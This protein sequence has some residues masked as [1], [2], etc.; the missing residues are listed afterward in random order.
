MKI[1]FGFCNTTETSQYYQEKGSSQLAILDTNRLEISFI[2]LPREIKDRGIVGICRDD[3]SIYLV[4]QSIDMPFLVKLNVNSLEIEKYKRL[5]NVFDPHSI[6]ARNDR[7]LI[8]S[9]GTNSVESF[10]KNTFKHTDTFWQ[11]P[12]TGR[13]KDIVH[14]N[15]IFE[16]KGDIWVSCFGLKT[17]K[18]WSTAREGYLINTKNNHKKYKISHPHSATSFKGSVYYCESS[19]GLVYKN[20]VVMKKLENSYARALEVYKNGFVVGISSSRIRSKSTGRVNNPS[21]TGKFM[22][23]SGILVVSATLKKEEFY[24]LTNFEKE[25][26]DVLIIDDSVKPNNVNGTGVVTK[27]NI[28]TE[29]ILISNLIEKKELLENELKKLKSENKN[30]KMRVKETK[31]LQENLDQIVSSK[32]YKIYRISR[33]FLILFFRFWIALLYFIVISLFFFFSALYSLLL[34]VIGAKK[35][36]S[37]RPLELDGVSFIIPTWNK[38]DMVIKCVTELDKIIQKEKIKVKKEIIVVDNGSIDGTSEALKNIK[39]STHLKIISLENNLGFA[40]AINKATTESKY[41]YIY[42]LNNDMFPQKGFLIHI[43]DL[44]S[45]YIKSRVTFFGIASQ[46]VMADQTKRREESGKTYLKYS[47]GFLNIAHC[48]L[49]GNLKSPSVTA[50][51]GGGSSLINKRVFLALGGYDH[52]VFKPLYVEDVDICFNAWRTGHPSFFCPDSVTI[53][54]HRSSSKKLAKKPDY[55][56]YNNY[57]VFILKNLDDTYLILRHLLF[58]SLRILTKNGYSVFAL[59]AIK[60]IPAIFKSRSRRKLLKYQTSDR[61]LLDFPKYEF[62]YYE[63]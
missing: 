53:H 29:N 35:K 41:N 54:R 6:L 52:E 56:M 3:K 47:L 44:T 63:K 32:T 1:L 60:N 17:G 20:G 12:N 50:Y 49:P 15:S 36:I 23:K 28:L 61:S 40:R 57:L 34:T 51:V 13:D 5:K 37:V 19:A 45:E 27:L 30:L 7:I 25:I 24:E 21:E 26:F 43:I 58:Y 33:K 8:C 2:K 9:T 48:V 31:R 38:R 11:H 62:E 10:D 16:L 59:E 46:I 18:M 4:T 22:A 39:T 55:Y 14:L 42:L